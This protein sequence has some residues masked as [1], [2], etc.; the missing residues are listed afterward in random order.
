MAMFLHC[1]CSYDSVYAYKTFLYMV[2]CKKKDKQ[3]RKEKKRESELTAG[4]YWTKCSYFSY[5]S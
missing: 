4:E 3:R 2:M 1:K 5:L